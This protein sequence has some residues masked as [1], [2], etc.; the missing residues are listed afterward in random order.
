MQFCPEC[1]SIMIPKGNSLNC[2]KCDYEIPI[3]SYGGYVSRETRTERVMTVI[4]GKESVGLPTTHVRCVECGNDTAYWWLRQL[5]S[6]DES[7]T[8]FFRCTECGK[9]WREYD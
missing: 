7:E 3:N 2:R 9:T 8:R 5:R 6:A 1:R 4:E